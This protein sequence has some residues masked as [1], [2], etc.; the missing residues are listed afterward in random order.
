MEAS[1]TSAARSAPLNPCI[2]VSEDIAFKSTL[3]ARGVRREFVIVLRISA[4]P[5]CVGRST[6]MIVSSRPGRSI[7]GSITSISVVNENSI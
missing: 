3:G 5:S 4:R 6:A 1:L 2:L 7:A